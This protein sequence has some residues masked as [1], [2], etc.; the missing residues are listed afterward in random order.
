[1]ASSTAHSVL[2]N[3]QVKLLAS[4]LAPLGSQGHPAS[5]EQ[6]APIFTCRLVYKLEQLAASKDADVLSVLER[7]HG[8]GLDARSR[9][10]L[11][12]RAGE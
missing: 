12:R 11:Y 8:R 9:V 10:W 7:A 1:M 2:S 3:W 4:L 6:Q 5:D